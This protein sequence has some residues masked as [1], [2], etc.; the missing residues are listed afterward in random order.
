M[1]PKGQKVEYW[2]KGINGDLSEFI[3]EFNKSDGW[4]VHQIIPFH[5]SSYL[6]AAYI[7]FYK[8]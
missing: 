3:K 5:G 1:I 8:Y 4:F 6:D 2:T 7:I